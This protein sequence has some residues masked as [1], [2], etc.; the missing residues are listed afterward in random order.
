MQRADWDSWLATIWG[1]SIKR[2]AVVRIRYSAS[3][4]GI[5]ERVGRMLCATQESITIRVFKEPLTIHYKR[6]RSV[7]KL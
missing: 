5:Q 2:K 1:R 3:V 6:I 4:K 7:E